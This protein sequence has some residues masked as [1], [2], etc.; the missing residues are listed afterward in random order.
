ML[1]RKII[2]DDFHAIQIYWFSG[3]NIHD[4]EIVTL[5]AMVAKY[6]ASYSTLIPYFQ[7]C[8]H[9]APRLLYIQVGVHSDKHIALL[10]CFIGFA[11]YFPRRHL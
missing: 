9:I 5:V 11:F 1:Y 4:F 3:S 7:L 6:D 8:G 10:F 2:I